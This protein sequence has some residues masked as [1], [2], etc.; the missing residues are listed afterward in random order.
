V[1]AGE[2]ASSA[3]HLA[4]LE[5]WL[6]SYRPEELFSETGALLPHLAALAPEGAARMSANPHSNGGDLV[7]PLRLPA[8]AEYRVE[9]PLP[10][11]ADAECTK[12]LAPMLRDIFRLNAEAKNFRIMY[13][14]INN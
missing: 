4:I 3:A 5:G 6:R 1:P 9:V 10:G 13:V 12:V 14:Y 7:V 2:C 8:P 11:A